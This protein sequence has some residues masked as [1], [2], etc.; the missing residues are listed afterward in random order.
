MKKLTLDEFT[1]LGGLKNYGKDGWAYGIYIHWFDELSEIMKSPVCYIDN[2]VIN[3]VKASDEKKKQ[4]LIIDDKCGNKYVFSFNGVITDE[5]NLDTAFMID[6]YRD[7]NCTDLLNMIDNQ[8]HYPNRLIWVKIR[9]N[10]DDIQKYISMVTGI[11]ED[12]I[13]IRIEEP[14]QQIFVHQLGQ[15]PVFHFASDDKNFIANIVESSSTTYQ[16]M[17]Y[18][19]TKLVN[20]IKLE[21]AKVGTIY[22]SVLLKRFNDWYKQSYQK[23]VTFKWGSEL[24]LEENDG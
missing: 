12:D 18:S 23:Q 6:E 7:L 11:D 9:T 19:S 22:K 17:I 4:T 8:M 16:I 14:I 1:E 5:N 10:L 24:S 13:R 21:G 20:A 15:M 2:I 3:P